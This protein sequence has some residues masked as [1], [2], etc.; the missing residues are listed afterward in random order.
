MR[1]RE[2]AALGYKFIKTRWIDVNKGDKGNPKYRS[3]LVGKEY[4]DGEGE[5]LFASTPPLE[6][7]RLLVSITATTQRD[8]KAN[9]KAIMINDVARAFFEAPMKKEGLR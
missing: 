9:R 3:R 7:L 4:N 6:A 8:R 5:N 2:A 1:R